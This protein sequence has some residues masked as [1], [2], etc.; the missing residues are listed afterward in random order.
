M[1]DTRDLGIALACT[2]DVVDVAPKPNSM[3]VQL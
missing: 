3:K 2:G 1:K